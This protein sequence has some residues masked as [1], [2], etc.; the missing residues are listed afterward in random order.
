MHNAT[1][2]RLRVVPGRVLDL[3]VDSDDPGGPCHDVKVLGQS[4]KGVP[5]AD[6]GWGGSSIRGVPHGLGGALRDDHEC[7]YF[8]KQQPHLR[9]T[10]LLKEQMT[11]LPLWL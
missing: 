3:W 4:D 9:C 2:H 7:V 10:E 1:H 6:F 11:H 8:P 5:T